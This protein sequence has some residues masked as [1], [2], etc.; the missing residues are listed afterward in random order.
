VESVSVAAALQRDGKILLAGWADDLAPPPP[1]PPA[2][3]GPQPSN[4]DFLVVRLTP[5]GALDPTFGSGGV[6]RT[7]IDLGNGNGDFAWAVAPGPG[8]TVVLA[9][10]AVTPDGGLDFAFVRYTSTGALDTSFSGDGVRT[11]DDGRFDYIRG[12]A[13]QP[14]GKIVA[15]GRGGGDGFAVIR[16][17]EN[18]APDA[19]FGSRGI[20]TTAIGNPTIQDEASAVLLVAGK[21]VVAGV[22]DW[23]N[24]SR[25]AFAV[26]RYLSNGQLDRSFGAGGIAV[27]RS[28]YDQRAWA[29]AAAPG[30]KIVVAG[31]SGAFRVARYLATGAPDNTF[32]GHGFAITSFEG[33][34]AQGRGVAVQADGKIVVGGLALSD[35]AERFAVAR[36]NINGALD[37]S[38]GD[39]GKRTYPIATRVWGGASVLKR[40]AASGGGDRFVVAGMASAGRG[41]ADHVAAIG[42]DLGAP[43]PPLMERRCRVPR[44]VHLSYGRARRKINRAHCSVGRMRFVLRPRLAGIVLAQSPRPGRVLRHKGRVNLVL[45]LRPEGTARRAAG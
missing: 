16:L 19:S 38:L 3:F 12:V 37:R 36:Y 18:G 43:G 40:G 11:V 4:A 45:G 10:D 13:V 39:N 30:G 2:P 14:D 15:V 6:V 1:P 21:I 44:V 24:P 27:S 35:A 8:G 23:Q 31:E 33:F 25:T 5:N 17:L 9:G 42:V 28:S 32:G 20:V 26:V 7:P 41:L 29:L 34:Y 22:A